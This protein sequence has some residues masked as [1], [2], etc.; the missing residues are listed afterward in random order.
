MASEK[1]EKEK[2]I[3]KLEQ[4]C[5]SK[6]KG[7]KLSWI[8]S[9]WSSKRGYGFFDAIDVFVFEFLQ[10]RSTPRRKISVVRG[11]FLSFWLIYY[12]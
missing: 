4:V 3:E 2:F 8:V 5:I 6:Q 10:P 7:D 9:L 1:H 12:L 11:S